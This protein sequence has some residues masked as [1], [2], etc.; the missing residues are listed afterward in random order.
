MTKNMEDFVRAVFKVQENEGEDKVV[1]LGEAVKRNI[2]PGMKVYFGYEASAAMRE[3]VRQFWGT[4]P[5]F[6][7]IMSYLGG[8]HATSLI[9]GGLVKKIVFSNC[10]DMYPTQKINNVIQQAYRKKAVEFEN[11]SLLSL[12]QRLMAGA[13]GLHLMPTRSLVGS[14]TAMD[15]IGSLR[16]IEDPFGSGDKVQLLKAFRPNISIV[17]GWAADQYGNTIL[18]PYKWDSLWGYKASENGIM[19]TVEK[20]VS[21]QFIRDHAP[22]VQ[23]PGFVVNSVSEVPFGAHP[24]G[25][26]NI[27]LEEFGGYAQDDQFLVEYH[28]KTQ[29]LEEYSAWI[30]GWILECANQRAYLRK[31]GHERI[32]FLSGKSNKDSWKYEL[33]SACQNISSRKAANA[34]ELMIVASSRYVTERV[35]RNKYRAIFSGVGTVG[36]AARVAYYDIRKRGYYVDLFTPGLGCTPMPG[37]PFLVNLVNMQTAKMFPDVFDMHGFT[38]GTQSGKCLALMGAAQIDKIGNINLTKVSEETYIAGA[39]GANDIASGAANEI[40]AL[41]PQSRSRFVERVYHI[42]CPGNRLKAVIS[43]KGVFKKVNNEDEL[44]LTGYFSNNGSE[45]DERQMVESIKADC[46]WNVK[47]APKLEM[48]SPPT[49]DELLILRLLDMPGYIIGR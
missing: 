29:D 16:T 14:D 47:I 17:H 37:D 35:L 19:V 20:L 12:H 28:R 18:A 23:I 1:N 9:S 39:G 27:G 7:L 42:T 40:I 31:L 11:W 30:K 25:L 10:S 49:P 2:K 33:N 13:L 21:T 15:N 44:S 4:R 45:A 3:V 8:T 41:V 22:W 48:I 38:A 36:L 32:M 43:T 5:Q 6:T 46:G 34:T 24:Q 26:A